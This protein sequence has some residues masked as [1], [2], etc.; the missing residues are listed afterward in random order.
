MNKQF[1]GSKSARRRAEKLKKDMVYASKSEKQ[2]II[3]NPASTPEEVAAA[4]LE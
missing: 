2:A 3:H 1:Q 4:R